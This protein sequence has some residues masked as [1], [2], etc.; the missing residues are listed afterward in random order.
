[1]DG[2]NLEATE[3][4]LSIVFDERNCPKQGADRAEQAQ[5]IGCDYA[6]AAGLLEDDIEKPSPCFLPRGLTNIRVC[7][8]I[9][10]RKIAVYKRHKY[11]TK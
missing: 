6:T 8:I 5:A 9:Q 7:D 4:R 11:L 10:S 1:M 2:S 3:K